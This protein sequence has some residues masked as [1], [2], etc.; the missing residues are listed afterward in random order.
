MDCRQE[1]IELVLQADLSLAI[2]SACKHFTAGETMH[3]NSLQKMDRRQECIELVLQ[4]DSSQ[5]IQSV[6]KHF[7]AGVTMH[8][9]SLQ[10]VDHKNLQIARN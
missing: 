7:T 9:T 10:K 8:A 6:C 3:A 4:A 1:C 5:A 2:Q